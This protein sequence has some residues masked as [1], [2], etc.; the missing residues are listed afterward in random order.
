[1][2][3]RPAG[4]SPGCGPGSPCTLSPPGSGPGLH[5]TGSTWLSRPLSWIYSGA[6][7][8][9]AGSVWGARVAGPGQQGGPVRGGW[10]APE[11]R[12]SRLVPGRNANWAAGLRRSWGMEAAGNLGAPR[13]N[14]IFALRSLGDSRGHQGSSEPRMGRSLRGWLSQHP[15]DAPSS[16]QLETQLRKPCTKDM[17]E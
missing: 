1:M 15:A 16:W 3:C 10:E 7:L 14:F 11:G 5:L 13:G 6:S 12:A 17:N 8:A 4:P 9:R 2:R